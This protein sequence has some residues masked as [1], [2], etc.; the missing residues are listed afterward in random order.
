MANRRYL[1][2][3]ARGWRIPTEGTA[4]RLIYDLM[5]MGCSRS[6]IA[7]TLGKNVK[8]VG[9]LMHRIRH[10]DGCNERFRVEYAKRRGASAR[11]RKA[12]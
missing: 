10:P 8:T 9:V 3:D 7:E 12:V 6:A 4:S 2:R 5:F 1:L 11:K